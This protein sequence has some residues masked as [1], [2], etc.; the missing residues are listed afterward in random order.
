MRALLN[1]SF[2]G[3]SAPIECSWVYLYRDWPELYGLQVCIGFGMVLVIGMATLLTPAIVERRDLDVGSAAVTQFRFL[4]G[5]AILSITTAVGNT[6]IRNVLSNILNAE[7]LV[8]LFRSTVT[9]NTLSHDV[10]N[11]VR[12]HFV[13]SLNLQIWILL[14]VAVAAVF[15]TLMMWQRPQI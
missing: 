13:Q 5:A 11:D 3:Y 6:W 2:H 8:E 10:Q 14:G 9:I 4:G 1:L 7:Q 15:S 12:G